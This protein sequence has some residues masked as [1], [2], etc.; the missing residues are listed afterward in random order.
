MPLNAKLIYI[1]YFLLIRQHPPRGD[2]YQESSG[3]GDKLIATFEM[4]QHKIFMTMG[5]SDMKHMRNYI[6]LFFKLYRI[7]NIGGL[8]WLHH[9][10]ICDISDAILT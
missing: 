5:S 1:T 4:R 8:K 10:Q 7:H 3:I 2:K 6:Q 9:N